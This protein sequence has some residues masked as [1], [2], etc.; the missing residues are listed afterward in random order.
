MTIRRFERGDRVVILAPQSRA[1]YANGSPT[2]GANGLRVY[3][4]VAQTNDEAI[5]CTGVIVHTRWGDKIKLALLNGRK[6][7]IDPIRIAHAVSLGILHAQRQALI[8]KI[9]ELEEA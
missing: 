6:I 4:L 5:V 8:D 9:K 1:V 2:F 3:E 7:F